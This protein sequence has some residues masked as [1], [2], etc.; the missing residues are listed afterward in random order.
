MGCEHKDFYKLNPKDLSHVFANF[1]LVIC[2]ILS[3]AKAPKKDEK[4]N[5][6]ADIVSLHMPLL[7]ATTAVHVTR[8]LRP[9]W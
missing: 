7:D 5:S 2:A 9:F 8:G 3:A 4:G 6:Y 1:L